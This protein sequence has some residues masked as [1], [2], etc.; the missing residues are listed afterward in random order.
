MVFPQVERVVYERNPLDE[1]ICQ[2]RFPAILKV[3]E[4]PIAFQEQIRAT[5]PFYRLK[6]AVK[7][8][9][10]V[11]AAVAAMFAR[12]L[13][14]G[15]SPSSHEF[16]SR[17]ENWTASLTREFLALTCRAYTRWEEF[18]SRFRELLDA[19]SRHYAPGFFT[20]V[21][22]RYRNVIR[23][24]TL[25]L[26]AVGWDALLK[27]WVAGPLNQPEVAAVIDHQFAEFCVRLPEGCGRV[28]AHHGF[29]PDDP[30]KDAYVIDADFF[31]DTQSEPND[32]LSRLESLH[33]QA[34]LFFRW[35]ISDRLHEALRPA[36]VVPARDDR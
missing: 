10:N 8:P 31:D 25:E 15:V 26:G 33:G 17:D 11:P 6:P 4:S 24:S 36:P 3:D 35:C 13:P 7:L 21:G 30:N 29:A 19:L 23:R 16:I 27:P 28:L 14:G 12:E 1:V 5:F 2:F 32:A 34:R 18:L 20:R 22:L 9:A